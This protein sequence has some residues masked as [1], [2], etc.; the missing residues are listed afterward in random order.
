MMSAEGVRWFFDAGSLA[1]DFG[2][3]GDFGYG[4]AAWERLHNPGDLDGWLGEHGGVASGG[5][6]PATE[7]DFAEALQLRAAIWEL[8][9]AAADGVGADPLS[10]DVVN[11][12]ARG[13]SPA[14]QLPGGAESAPASTAAMLLAAVARDAVTVFSS[15]DR[16]RRCG[17]EDCA[18]IFHDGSRTQARR[19]CSMQRCGNRQKVR[20]HRARASE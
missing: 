20:M 2:Y 3:T 4:V 8:A 13:L 1:L 18:L 10:I 6:L 5:R 12:F 14:P 9:R 7:R 16:I 17:A 11:R 19:W 15:P